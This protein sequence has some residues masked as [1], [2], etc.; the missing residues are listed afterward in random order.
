MWARLQEA[1]NTYFRV[2]D[3]LP[4]WIDEVSFIYLLCFYGIIHTRFI[5]LCMGT[6][7]ALVGQL[8][9]AHFS[10]L[11]LLSQLLHPLLAM[12]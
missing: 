2:T 12:E 10:L 8:S 5:L 3:I 1:L 9:F 11:Q 4:L 7:Y 6:L